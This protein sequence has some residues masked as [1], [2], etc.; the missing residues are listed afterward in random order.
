[1]NYL[2]L[3]SHLG[4]DAHGGYRSREKMTR[5][6]PMSREYLSV[7]VTEHFFEPIIRVASSGDE[8]V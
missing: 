7:F 2:F 6:P 3:Q 8:P 5:D 4:K 1:M